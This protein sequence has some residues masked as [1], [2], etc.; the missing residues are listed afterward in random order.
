MTPFKIN[1]TNSI[2]NLNQLEKNVKS[3]Q[4]FEES[5]IDELIAKIDYIYRLAGGE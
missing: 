4:D 3:L 2:D 1:W 5:D